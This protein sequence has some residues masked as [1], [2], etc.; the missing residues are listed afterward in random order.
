MVAAGSE[1]RQAYFSFE[2]HFDCFSTNGNSFKVS[3]R[4]CGP[5]GSHKD[6]SAL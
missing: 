3:S 4:P 2:I 5:A 1:K 6:A